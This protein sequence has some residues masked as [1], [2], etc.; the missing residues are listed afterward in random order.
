MYSSF[1]DAGY[2]ILF[3]I[4]FITIIIAAIYTLYSNQCRFTCYCLKHTINI[5]KSKTHNL[6]TIIVWCS[7]HPKLFCMQILH[8]FCFWF[9]DVAE[10]VEC[11]CP[12]T[13]QSITGAVLVQF[14]TANSLKVMFTDSWGAIISVKNQWYP[15]ITNIKDEYMYYTITA[16]ATL[17]Y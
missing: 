6:N 17:A 10:F 2:T 7:C 14:M 13:S 1:E 9:G 8:C 12:S 5:E 4:I 16:G 15:K 11:Y 3:S